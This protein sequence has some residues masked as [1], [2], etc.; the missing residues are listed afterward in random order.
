MSLGSC[1]TDPAAFLAEHWSQRPV[2]DRGAPQRFSELLDEAEVEEVVGMRGLRLPAFRMVRQGTLIGT[3]SYTMTAPLGQGEVHDLIDPERV[4]RL[5]EDGATLI[6]RGLERYHPAIAAF[7]RALGADL[8]HPV[9]ANA[10]VT[11]ANAQGHGIHYDLHDVFVLQC[12]GRKHWRVH[13]RQV[14]D[15]VPGPDVDPYVRSEDLRGAVVDEVLAPGDSLYVPR[16]W[17]HL[18]STAGQASIHLT[19]GVH[20]LTWLDVLG[21]VLERARACPE[22]RAAIPPEANG[23]AFAEGLRAAAGTLGALLEQTPPAELDKLMRDRGDAALGLPA[24]QGWVPRAP[25]CETT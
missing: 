24:R 11:P 21:A 22:L 6:L 9:R 16:G 5:F 18:A 23:T 10:Y 7:C 1:M 25:S 13:E 4:A 17:P 15:P 2:L 8:G 12:S 3:D 19:L 20:V 14:V